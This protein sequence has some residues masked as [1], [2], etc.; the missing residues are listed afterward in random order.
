MKIPNL[1]T[2]AALAASAVSALPALID[3]AT[4]PGNFDIGNTSP[5][6]FDPK[7]P[8]DRWC[9]RHFETSICIKRLSDEGLLA[10]RSED[11]AKDMENKNFIGGG[12]L[13]TDLLDIESNDVNNLDRW[14][15]TR[16]ENPVCV[17]RAMEEAGS[18]S[19]R[20]LE[21]A[22]KVVKRKGL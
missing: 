11:A 2:T 3:S 16:V 20:G 6:L 8:V 7:D 10:K 5:G 15:I 21:N 13:I 12:K 17:K 4:I 14:C 19:K 9:Q 18:L 22:E 1:L